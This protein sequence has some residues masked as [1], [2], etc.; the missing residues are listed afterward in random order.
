MAILIQSRSNLMRTSH[1]LVIVMALFLAACAS[2]KTPNLVT[3]VA[4]K[5]APPVLN[6]ALPTMLRK[7]RVWIAAQPNESD[8][9][10]LQAEGVRTII[11]V[12]TNEEM[13]DRN[14]VP[15]DEAALAMEL[16]MAYSL[17]QM[18]G[19]V[20]FNAQGV[21]ALERALAAQDGPVLLHCA[22]GGRAGLVWAALQI[23]QGRD[24]DTVMRELEP[25]G[26]WPLSIEK[27]SGVPMQL[28]RKQE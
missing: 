7:G 1:L 12:R 10:A 9:R 26:L 27:V 6:S 19:S 15:F 11:N 23:R 16:G 8:L 20:G 24:P 21:S 2:T 22:S 4:A 3:P 18:G 5:S 14:S 13:A 28:Q 17:N 25:L